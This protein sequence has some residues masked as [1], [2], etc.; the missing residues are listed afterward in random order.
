M[1]IMFEEPFKDGN[2]FGSRNIRI[3][4]IEEVSNADAMKIKR[5]GG[6]FSIVKE[7]EK[8]VINNKKQDEVVTSDNKPRGK[9]ATG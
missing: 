8:K 2:I 4:T 5:S 9:N 3:G 7:E 6:V 1:R